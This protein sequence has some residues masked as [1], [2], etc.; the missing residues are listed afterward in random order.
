MNLKTKLKQLTVMMKGIR[1]NDMNKFIKPKLSSAK[2]VEKLRDEKG[3]T[4]KYTSEQEAEKFLQDR[5]NYMRTAA[6]RKNFEK[7]NEGEHKGKYINLD[8]A[9]LQELSVIDMHLRHLITKMCLDIEHDLKVRMVKDAEN[10]LLVDGYDIVEK[11]LNKNPYIVKKLEAL[12]TSP[13]TNALLF[14]Y[15][16][17]APKINNS[18]GK[19]YNTIIAYND[20]PVWVFLELITFGDLIH[21][22]E[23]YYS[24]LGEQP[25]SLTLINL[26][27]SLRNGSA[28][29]N[30]ILADITKGSSH[31]PAVVSQ[32]VALIKGITKSQRRKALSRRVILELTAMLLL[33]NEVVSEKV[34][35]HRMKEFKTFIN[36]RAIEKKVF[37]KDNLLIKS[38]YEFIYKV[39]YALYP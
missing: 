31:I 26:T 4:F 9:Y 23:F 19:M 8:F 14:K 10:N 21:F 13:F 3:V 1:G 16:T 12:S 24:M 34:K 28:H 39:I 5:N 6:Y 35:Y 22:Y 20:C 33:Y 7:Y 38:T 29:N 2:L 32:K 25:V 15:F 36:G 27:K 30:C 11:F 37:F 18:T 17:I